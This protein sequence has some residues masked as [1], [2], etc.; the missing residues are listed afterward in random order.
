[1]FDSLHGGDHASNTVTQ[2]V[3]LLYRTFE[4][5]HL[6]VCCGELHENRGL[7]DLIQ[8]SRRDGDIH[9][10]IK[11]GNARENGSLLSYGKLKVNTVLSE[12]LEEKCDCI[13]AQ[14]KATK[15]ICEILICYTD[16]DRFTDDFDET[17]EECAVYGIV[18]EICMVEGG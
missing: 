8:L 9:T 5:L 6:V 18:D 2:L 1:M 15:I 17:K 13:L 12:S 3:E 11:G 7:E 10:P 4:G 16:T 14:T